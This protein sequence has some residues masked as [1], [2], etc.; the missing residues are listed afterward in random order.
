MFP[1]I[2][3]TPAKK[4]KKKPEPG[5]PL[6]FG[7]IFTD[8]MFIMDYV[9]GQGWIHPRIEEYAPF[10]IEP[11]SMVF[12]YAQAVFEGLKAYRNPDT[13][14][15][16][17][18]PKLNFERMNLSN[19]RM[20]IPT[21]DVDFCVHALKELVRI[22]QGWIPEGEGESLYIR[23]FVIATDPYVGVKASDTYRFMIILSPSG[24]YYAQGLN[25]V[26][27]YVENVFVRA[28]KGGTGFTK[29]AG[30]YA[31]SLA[32]QEIAHQKG[33]TQV[34]WLDGVE[35]KY[36]EEVGAMNI[37]FVIDGKVVT[38]ELNGSI[39]SGITRKSCLELAKSLNLTVEERKISIDE[40]ME[41]GQSGRLGEAFGTG[42]AAVISPV[43][44]LRYGDTVITINDG[45]IGPITQI[46]YDTITQIQ[47]GVREDTF[48]WIEKV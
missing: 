28:V 45:K 18:R 48:H 42:T 26:S 25:P 46:F 2:K 21:V 8:H 19:E 17:F 22:D 27:I 1:E 36:I 14:V 12:H 16:L 39:L 44:E 9:K 35:Q 47:N 4:L 3:F 30:N 20:A 23:P 10:L 32:A 34:L 38:P 33:Y 7:K 41:A 43:G 37:L 40:L 11:S 29:C 6:P 15:S 24:A 31:A 13:S 5:S